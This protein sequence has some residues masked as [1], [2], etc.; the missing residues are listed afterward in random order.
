MPDGK[1]AGSNT[2]GGHAAHAVHSPHDFNVSVGLCCCAYFELRECQ[3][4]KHIGRHRLAEQE[5]LH[6]I[7]IELL[8]KC[9]LSDSLDALRDHLHAKALRH[10]N[11]GRHDRN[12]VGIVRQILDKERSTLSRWIGKRFRYPRLE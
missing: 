11:H 3:R 2:G 12:V 7:A 6:P 4:H 8:Q 1:A 9:A 5:A 10:R